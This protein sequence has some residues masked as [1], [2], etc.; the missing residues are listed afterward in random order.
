MAGPLPRKKMYKHLLNNLIEE[1]FFDNWRATSEICEAI[2]RDVPSRWS[3]IANSS[4]YRYMRK[5]HVK[6]RYEWNRSMGCMLRE[7][8]KISEKNF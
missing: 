1:G 4:I 6:E 8:K 7:W 2:N 3:P 5:T